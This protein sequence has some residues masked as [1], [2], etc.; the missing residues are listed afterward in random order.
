M[1]DVNE[2]NEMSFF[3][4]KIKINSRMDHW[5]YYSLVEHMG[6]VTESKE[7]KVCGEQFKNRSLTLEFLLD[8]RFP[9]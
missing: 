1:V 8:V 5:N 2:S 4:I 3:I 6:G 9:L 7:V